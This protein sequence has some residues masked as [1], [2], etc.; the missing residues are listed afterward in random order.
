MRKSTST[1]STSRT[2]N[3]RPPLSPSLATLALDLGIARELGLRYLTCC[4][5]HRRAVED[6]KRRHGIPLAEYETLKL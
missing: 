5:E 4:R 1:L 6:Y 3:D 2:T